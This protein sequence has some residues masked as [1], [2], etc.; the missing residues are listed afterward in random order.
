MSTT[1]GRTGHYVHAREWSM[2]DFPLEACRDALERMVNSN[3]RTEEICSVL[4]VHRKWTCR[5][6][7]GE[8]LSP[9]YSYEDA[10]IS[11]AREIIGPGADG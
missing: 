3:S 5:T 6:A 9:Q 7:S 1:T 4:W 10:A 2:G 11:W 8:E